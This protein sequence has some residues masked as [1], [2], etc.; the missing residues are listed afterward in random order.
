MQERLHRR[1]CEIL[2][3][4]WIFLRQLASNSDEFRI[5]LVERHSRFEPAHNR[6]RGI[7]RADDELAARYRRKLIVKRRPEFL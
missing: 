4:F 7:V 3:R 2:V 6:R 5:R 1:R